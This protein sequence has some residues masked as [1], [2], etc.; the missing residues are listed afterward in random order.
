MAGDEPTSSRM[1]WYLMQKVTAPF[2]IFLLLIC[3]LVG[4]M[5]APSS[6]HTQTILARK[7]SHD[8]RNESQ[9]YFINS[10]GQGCNLIDDW[11]SPKGNQIETE[12]SSIYFFQ[13]PL[14]ISGVHHP[15]SR[16]L[17]RMIGMLQVDIH[18]YDDWKI[19]PSKLQ[20]VIESHLAFRSQTDSE[21]YWKGFASSVEQRNMECSAPT[22]K[23]YLHTCSLLPIF[24][25]GSIHHDYYLLNLRFPKSGNKNQ[26]LGPI[27]DLFLITISQSEQF[28][29]VWLSLKTVFFP[30]VIIILA[31]FWRRIQLLAQQP[32]LIESLLISLGLSLSLHNLP[33]EYLTLWL[34][35][36]FMQLIVDAKQQI[37]FA[38]LFSFWLVLAGEHFR[39][40]P[41][42]HIQDLATY[43]RTLYAIGVGCL[44]VLIFNV[45]EWSINVDNPFHFVWS[46]EVV[47]ESRLE[48]NY[49]IIVQRSHDSF[50]TAYYFLDGF[51]YSLQHHGR[52]LL[53]LFSGFGLRHCVQYLDPANEQRGR[54]S[55]TVIPIRKGVVPAV[56]DGHASH[57]SLCHADCHRHDSSS[58]VAFSMEAKLGRNGSRECVGFLHGSVWRVELLRNCSLL[59]L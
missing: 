6:L 28:A 59:Y 27:T 56:V 51:Y 33:L 45:C 9:F 46:T 8:S 1:H 34:D 10:T 23:H 2:L 3:F 36:P 18:Y 20:V 40:D 32:N 58:G 12:N 14:P 52:F 55:H 31:R 22:K 41:S 21:D 50:D 13:M 35:L 49:H 26:R 38:T 5:I 39:C 29:K 48:V 24:H 15:Y 11:S 7:C 25:L 19:M 42:R 53:A 4:G 54:N 47:L 43:K 30:L 16:W 57:T 17:N 44:S 37:F